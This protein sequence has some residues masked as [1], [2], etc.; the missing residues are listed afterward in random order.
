MI[1]AL[2]K[3]VSTTPG[4]PISLA[5]AIPALAN[6]VLVQADFIALGTNT[7]KTYFGNSTLNKTTGAG[8]YVGTG[9]AANQTLLLQDLNA[10]VN[11][12]AASLASGGAA[13]SMNANN[14]F[15]DVDTTGEGFG[16]Y[17]TI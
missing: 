5:A 13:A 2:A 12:G 16:G 9:I 14:I 1:I 15:F 17:V 3:I 7:G 8:C 4:T 10:A 6:V 11:R